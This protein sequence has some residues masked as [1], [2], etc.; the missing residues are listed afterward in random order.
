MEICKPATNIYEPAEDS[1]LLQRF[2]RKYALGRVLD[3]GTGSGIQ[4]LTAAEA[5]NVKEVIAADI[6]EESIISLQKKIQTQKSREI[7]KNLRNFKAVKSDLFQNVKGQFDLIIFNPPYLPQDKGIIDIALYGGKKGW[8]ISDRFF[9]E[10]SN[11]L[12]PDGK[13]LFL[14]SS[15]TNQR[16]IDEIIQRNLFSSKL[17]AKEKLPLFEELYVYEVVKTP[18]LKELEGKG[19]KQIHY[20][21]R[22]KRGVVYTGMLSKR[23]SKE[24]HFLKKEIK[25]NIKKEIIQVAI[26]AKRED[27]KANGR[28]ANE[29]KWLRVLNKKGIGP[30]L[31]FAGKNYLV[32]EFIR[33]SLILDWIE[34]NRSNASENIKKMLVSVL[35]QCFKM[36]KLAINKEEMHRPIKH[37]I[38]SNNK[39]NKN[40]MG[41]SKIS[42]DNPVLIDF[43]RCYKTKKPHNVTQFIEFICKIEQQLNQKNIIIGIK[44][45]REAAG[46]YKRDSSVENFKKILR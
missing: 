6:N 25:K 38:I 36:D 41:S 31:L 11:H 7:K 42:N 15:H 33:G 19:I 34:S 16:K 44:E 43:E 3:M 26:K 4:A 1:Y 45:L 32:S 22:G 5:P 35:K 18:L 30:E 17:L 46:R 39:I 23:M 24:K 12:L 37:V 9:K 10:A 20:H 2:V 28:I 14:F 8:E 21:T 40:E 29:A 13:I 27:S